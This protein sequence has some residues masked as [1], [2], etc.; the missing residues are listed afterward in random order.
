MTSDDEGSG[1]KSPRETTALFGHAGA[2]KALLD[3]YKSGR[4]AHAWLIGGPPGIGKT[5]LAYRIARFVLAHPEPHSGVL[6][7]LVDVDAS[8]EPGAR[9]PARAVATVK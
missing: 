8:G 4:T 6:G 3:A 7:A 9:V 1:A 2:E 5:T